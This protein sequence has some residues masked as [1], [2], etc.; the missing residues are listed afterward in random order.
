[1]CLYD[2]SRTCSDMLWLAIFLFS[3]TTTTTAAV[4]RIRASRRSLIVEPSEYDFTEIDVDFYV[5]TQDCYSCFLFVAKIEIVDVHIDDREVTC[6]PGSG[7]DISND[8]IISVR[9]VIGLPKSVELSLAVSFCKNFAIP[10]TM[11]SMQLSGPLVPALFSVFP[12][13]FIGPDARDQRKETDLSLSV[14]VFGTHYLLARVRT[15]CL[16]VG[17]L[18]VMSLSPILLISFSRS[19]LEEELAILKWWSCVGRRTRKSL[20]TSRR[21]GC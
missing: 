7:S 11:K 21:S 16:F 6:T 20:L 12:L 9:L 2:L 19:D 4:N 18:C 15:D 17:R 13:M 14:L 3:T 10:M 8:T 5:F 1:M